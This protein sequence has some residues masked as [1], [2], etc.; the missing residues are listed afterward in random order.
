[1]GDNNILLKQFAKGEK[2][3]LKIG[4]RAVIYQRV[5]SKEQEEGFSPE[6]QLE[7]C[8]EW[9]A[10]H[11]Y[12]VVECFEGEHESA[13]SDTNRKRFN[14]MLKYVKNKKNRVDAV[15]VYSTSRFSRT[16]TKSFTIIDELLDMGIPVFSATCSYDPRTMDGKMMQRFDLLRAEHDNSVKSQAVKDNGA[17]ALRV[18]RWIQQ[19]PR[20]YDMK[21]TRASQTIT[22]NKEGELI[23]KAFLMKANEG[24]T[25][26]EVRVRMKALGL[27]LTKQKWSNIF[28]NIFYAGYFAHKFLEGEV[29]PGPHEPLVS[30]DV[31]CKVNNIVLQSHTRGYEVKS[32][33]EYA[34]LLGSIRC[35]VCGNNLTASLSTK[36]RKKYGREIGY[37]VCSRKNCRC[38]VSTKTA[39]GVF[40]NK[41]DGVA[42]PEGIEELLEAQ[43]RKSFPILNN[44]GQE[45]ITA[46]KSNLTKKERE[47][48]TIEFNLATAA[49]PKMKDICM[50]QLERLEAERDDILKEIEEKDKSIL[51]LNDY[52]STGLEMK[53]K[54]LKLWQLSNLSYKRRLQNLIFPDGIVWRKENDDIE[55]LSKNEFLFTYGLKSSSYGDKESGQT[56]F[57]T[58]LSAWAPQL[59]LEPRTP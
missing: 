49:S 56:D 8:Y 14:T 15:I 16:G 11:G 29:I 26:E 34:P 22:I 33:K 35:P 21:T 54:I 10:R 2:R 44:S 51:N 28:R 13:K 9:A 58:N 20:G 5:S 57:S 40:E 46:L 36:M 45:E 48:E 12:E 25:N 4:G 50:K 38:N 47:I 30:L 31:F 1:M 23:R 39:N 52:I 37:Y 3:Q 42:L 53:D 7:R 18:G 27:D 17:R 32:D 19:A 55:P 6:T 41:I 43:L 59:G 24:L